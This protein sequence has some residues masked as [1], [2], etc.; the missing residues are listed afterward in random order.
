MCRP[1]VAGGLAGPPVS[2]R[3]GQPLAGLDSSCPLMLLFL[4]LLAAITFT[5][6]TGTV[7]HHDTAAIR[8]PAALDRSRYPRSVRAHRR[9]HRREH[10]AGLADLP[11]AGGA[12][13][14]LG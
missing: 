10:G 4:T 13:G 1:E 8:R 3:P 12:G 14:P 6:S 7:D 5:I 2:P 9:G 11:C